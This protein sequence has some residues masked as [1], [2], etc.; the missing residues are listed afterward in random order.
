M[1]EISRSGAD[2]LTVENGTF[3]S[4][5]KVSYKMIYFREHLKYNFFEASEPNDD[6]KGSCN[7]FGARGA[8]LV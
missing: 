6:C 7:D 3:L 8:P 2:S 4:S 1:V 5:K